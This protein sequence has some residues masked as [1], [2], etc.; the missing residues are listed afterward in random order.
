MKKRNRLEP[1]DSP[2]YYHLWAGHWVDKEEQRNI[3]LNFLDERGLNEEFIKYLDEHFPD[4]EDGCRE[5][6]D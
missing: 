6:K 3:L 4:N 1:P 2:P 5:V